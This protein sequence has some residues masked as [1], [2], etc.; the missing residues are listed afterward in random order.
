MEKIVIILNDEKKENL[1]NALN[2]IKDSYDAF[3]IENKYGDNT[4]KKQFDL[5]SKELNLP[6]DKGAL[7]WIKYEYDCYYKGDYEDE[8]GTAF[9]YIRNLILKGE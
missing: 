3:F 5:L 4:H 7:A 9:E 6:L 8:T 2:E 1:L